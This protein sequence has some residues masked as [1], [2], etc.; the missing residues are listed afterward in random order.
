MALHPIEASELHARRERV[1][2]IL[3][4]LFLGTLAML[5][6]LGILRFIKLGEID[7]ATWGTLT[8]SVAVG[9]LPYPVTFLCTDLISEIYGRARAS[10]VVWMGL[11][12][13]CWVLIILWVGGE[14]P[15]FETIDPMTGTPA[16]DAANRQPVF[17]EVRAFAF[18]ATLASMIAYLA[19][20]FTDVWM[21][22]FWKNLTGGKH[23][24]LRN[25]GSTVISQLVDSTAVI[26]ITFS[27]GG[28]A[29]VLN[30]DT[31]LTQ[32]LVVLILTGYAFKF[33][34]A[35]LDTVPFYF[36]TAWLSR[37]LE[38]DPN[39]EHTVLEGEGTDSHPTRP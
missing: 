36:M 1:F 37:Y 18:G 21:F 4:G 27:I 12:L 15:G 5:N 25:N 33:F 6:I 30:D 11:V 22:H 10:A 17:F 8:F 7:T 31:P 29:G 19:A 32:Q 2:L 34:F 23:L 16:G 3:A 20:Q 28:L 13:N 24:W 9:V 39:Q 26:L 14:L 38:I 35:L